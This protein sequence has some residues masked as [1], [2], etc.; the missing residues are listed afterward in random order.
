MVT[1]LLIFVCEGIWEMAQESWSWEAEERRENAMPA[2][3]PA[4][5]SFFEKHAFLR[6]ACRSK[7]GFLNTPTHTAGYDGISRL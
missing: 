5:D 6:K 7:P 1:P 2:L 3:V 4:L